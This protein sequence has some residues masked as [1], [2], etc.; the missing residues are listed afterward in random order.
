[1]SH[2]FDI[3]GTVRTLADTKGIGLTESNTSSPPNDQ[4][5]TLLTPR[6][7][8]HDITHAASP[9]L[10]VVAPTS[11]EEVTTP[12]Q[13]DDKADVDVW[14][15]AFSKKRSSKKGKRQTAFAADED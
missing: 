7:H 3:P 4:E 12:T 10:A 2:R 6:S 9:D 8:S 14:P 15:S 11:I 13:A 1:M 5:Y